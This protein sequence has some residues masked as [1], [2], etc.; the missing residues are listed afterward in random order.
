LSSGPYVGQVG[1]VPWGVPASEQPL[2]LRHYWRALR[3]YRAVVVVLFLLGLG[4][5]LAVLE[6]SPATSEARALVLVPASFDTGLGHPALDL[7]T[8]VII[9]GSNPV[10][11][12]ARASVTP[13]MP[14]A[15]LR[16]DLTVSALSD[17]VLQIQVD[18][19]PAADAVKLADAVATGYVAYVTKLG[20][21]STGGVVSSLQVES[22]QLTSQILSLQDQITAA[23]DRLARER[24]SSVA[25]QRDASL[26][27][28]L[29][30]EQEAVSLQLDNVNSQLVTA[31]LSN[32]S[33]ADAT[34]VLQKATLVPGSLLATVLPPVAGALFGL[35]LGALA[36]LV[37]SRG[38]RRLRL[39]DEIAAAIGVPVVASFA[40]PRCRSVKD[41]KKLLEQGQPSAVE[42][43]SFRRV[44]HRLSQPLPGKGLQQG[45]GSSPDGAAWVEAARVGIVAFAGDTAALGA[46]PRL[47]RAAAALGVPARLVPGQQAA[48]A[49]LRAA[50]PVQG[51]SRTV[52]DMPERGPSG[53]GDRDRGGSSSVEVEVALTAMEEGKPE[54]PGDAGTTLLAVSAGYATL[55]SL[56]KLA[57]AADD[58]GAPVE[59]IL[60]VNPEP[61]DPT[62]GAVASH[63]T[64]LRL[65]RRVAP[66]SGARSAEGEAR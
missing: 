59:G 29:R 5:G 64:P 53:Y 23:S 17:E 61:G 40:V 33:N 63:S 20:A 1:E 60:V 32:T 25:G 45:S 43:W 56:A 57:L 66:R 35:L 54:L 21:S 34:R 44:L 55:D 38:D 26:V 12:G 31:Q 27:G 7:A 65:Q 11:A 15:E 42:M 3:R 4:G 49:T 62:T 30:A 39:R 51:T 48:L 58:A 2:N 41:W 28:S 24:P 47:V 16:S 50:C 13:P 37:L 9:A 8:Q 19:A 46:G 18:A 36:T 52:P 10:L 6:H 22:G 14:I